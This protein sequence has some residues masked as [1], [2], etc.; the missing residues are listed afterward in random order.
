MSDELDEVMLTALIDLIG[1][2][3]VRDFEIRHDAGDGP[4]P[5]MVWMAI[6]SAADGTQGDCAAS[7]HPVEATRR[8]AEQIIDGG[9]C[10]HCGQLTMIDCDPFGGSFDPIAKKMGDVVGMPGICHYR[11]DPETKRFRRSCEGQA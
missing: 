3:G 8:L 2:T 6:V 1:R 9:L 4:A 7:F 11:L 10:T 5:R